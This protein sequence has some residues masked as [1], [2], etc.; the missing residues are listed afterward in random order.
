MLAGSCLAVLAIVMGTR[1]AR[2][3]A[4]AVGLA[5]LLLGFVVAL[6]VGAVDDAQDP[7]RAGAWLAL[8]GGIML[9]AGTVLVWRASPQPRGEGG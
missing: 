9:V 8:G 6:P 7:L 5:C 4:F 1:H 3:N 2:A